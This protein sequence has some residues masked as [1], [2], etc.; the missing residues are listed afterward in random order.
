MDNY[1][2]L[3]ENKEKLIVAMKKSNENSIPVDFTPVDEQIRQL[4]DTLTV[5]SFFFFFYEIYLTFSLS[6][7]P[8]N[9][10]IGKVNSI[11]TFNSGRIFI[12][13]FVIYKNGSIKLKQLSV[14][15]TMITRISFVNIKNSYTIKT[16]IFFINLLNRAE[17]FCIFVNP[18]NNERFNCSLKL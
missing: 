3:L 7:S 10:L 14:K 16:M 12:N 8:I 15:N 13:V 17:I 2:I 6:K 1:R 5:I 18:M 11:I 9:H 4:V